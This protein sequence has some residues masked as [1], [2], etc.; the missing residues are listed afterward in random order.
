MFGRTECE[1]I[2]RSIALHCL[3]FKCLLTSNVIYVWK[4]N[5]LKVSWIDPRNLDL[6]A[7]TETLTLVISTYPI[8]CTS[9]PLSASQH[10]NRTNINPAPILPM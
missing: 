10:L 3:E 8:I 2:S 6:C 5:F 9:I 7:G 4:R 1:V